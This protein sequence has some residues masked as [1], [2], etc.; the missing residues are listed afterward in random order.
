MVLIE[1]GFYPLQ[2]LLIYTRQLNFIPRFQD[3]E[4]TSVRKVLFN[5]IQQHSKY[6]AHY[7]NLSRIYNSKEDIQSHYTRLLKDDIN[8]LAN[9]DDNY[10]FM[11]YKQFNPNLVS[12][13]DYPL[14]TRLRLSSH[15]MPIETGRWRR[16][17]RKD[18]LCPTCNTLGDE[19]H[20]IY[21]C[22]DVDRS[23]LED[24]PPIHLLTEY[25]KLPLLLTKLKI[26]L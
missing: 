17:L 9:S 22:P 10:K 16:V 8:T 7:T 3:F 4:E 11:L 24:I 25:E 23:E 19:K 2:C 13:T 12:F 18:R 20:Y 1:S 5:H 15:S 6:I 26:Y 21:T 14:F